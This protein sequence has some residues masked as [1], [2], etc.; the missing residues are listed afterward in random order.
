[1]ACITEQL[2]SE[3]DDDTFFTTLLKYNPIRN[4]PLTNIVLLTGQ[5]V[6]ETWA[7]FMITI[8]RINGMHELVVDGRK[9]SKD[10]DTEEVTISSDILKVVLE[11]SDPHLMWMYLVT[12]YKRDMVYALV[13]QVGILCQLI[14]AYGS[15][16]TIADYI[17][18]FETEWNK[19][20]R[21]AR[22]KNE[23]YRQD[24]AKFL[25]KDLAKR[26][27]LLGFLSRY[28]RNV[29]D[30]LTTKSD[31]TFAAVKQHLLDINY[32]EVTDTNLIT[33]SSTI[34]KSLLS[35]PS[36]IVKKTKDNTCS[37]CKKHYPKSNLNYRWFKCERLKE[38]KKKIKKDIND[39]QDKKINEPLITT[40]SEEVR[41]PK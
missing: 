39:R 2:S 6:Y 17:Q 28:K 25:Q 35:R 40:T 31:L 11:Q 9:P 30:N 12:E 38:D 37:Y 19:L 13:Y 10:A 15:L 5:A 18:L 34:E 27:F 8:W 1:M 33:S 3:N 24:F 32:E 4:Y 16:N 36:G 29:V 41:Q 26:D 22:D 7:I 21:L 14:T 23:E 20:Y